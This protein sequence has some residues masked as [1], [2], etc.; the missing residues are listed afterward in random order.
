MQGMSCFIGGIPMFFY[1]DEVGYLNDYAYLN[2]EAKNYDNRWMHRP[3]IDWRKNERIHIDGS[4][5]AKI[6]HAT[7]RLIQIRKK[8]SI[9]SD[10]NNLSWLAPYNIHVAAFQRTFEKEK[11]YCLFNFSNKKSYISWYAFKEQGI[12][13]EEMYDHWN[14]K[15]HMVGADHEYFEM[16]PYSFCL[17]EAKVY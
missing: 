1:G 3:L 17:L 16:E 9:V 7:K 8:L 10:V 15:R 6:Y 13:S 5:E 12:V 11:L 2:E 4:V 14:E